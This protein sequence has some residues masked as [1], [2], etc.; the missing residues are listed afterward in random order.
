MGP[1]IKQ[2]PLLLQQLLLST[3]T[4]RNSK[5]WKS[6]TRTNAI[7]FFNNT[8]TNNNINRSAIVLKNKEGI[9]SW[10][11]SKKKHCGQ[12]WRSDKNCRPY[13][14]NPKRLFL[15]FFF[16][17]KKKGKTLLGSSKYKLEKKEYVD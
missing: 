15:T 11:S 14:K 7:F 4:I 8:T 3:T 5:G 2:H 16:L 1:L 9:A 6:L 10:L 12:F 13:S 17:N